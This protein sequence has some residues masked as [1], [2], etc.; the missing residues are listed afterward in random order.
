MSLKQQ[1][2]QD[3]KAAM[4]AGETQTVTVLRGLKV[5]VLNV[6]IQKGSP[7]NRQK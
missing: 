4:L 3:L 5:A 7:E 1:I 6:E 2:D